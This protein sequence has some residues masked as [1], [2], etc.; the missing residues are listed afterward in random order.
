MGF[1]MT[2]VLWWGRWDLSRT[3]GIIGGVG[4][5]SSGVMEERGEC[6]V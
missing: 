6:L 3:E 2:E 1:G 4:I 5:V